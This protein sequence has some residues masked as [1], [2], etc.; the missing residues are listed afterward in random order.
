MIAGADY[1][2][3]CLV[4]GGTHLSADVKAAHARQHEIEHHKG[5]WLVSVPLQQLKRSSAICAG[6]NLESLDE[7]GISYCFSNGVVIFYD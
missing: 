4:P 7:E 5:K 6:R 1:E 2:N 3:G